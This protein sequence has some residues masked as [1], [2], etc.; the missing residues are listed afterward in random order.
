MLTGQEPPLMLPQPTRLVLAPA[1]PDRK[2][3]LAFPVAEDDRERDLLDFGVPDPLAHGL[4]ARVELCAEVLIVQFV[5][6]LG[7]HEAKCLLHVGAAQ[8]ALH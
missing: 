1:L 5:R 4:V 2:D 6:K 8:I 7:L 3:L